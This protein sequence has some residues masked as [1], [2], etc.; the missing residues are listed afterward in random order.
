MTLNSRLSFLPITASLPPCWSV[1]ERYHTQDQPICI[2][3]PCHP[4]PGLGGQPTPA[5]RWQCM[6]RWGKAN[7]IIGSRGRPGSSDWN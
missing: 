3:S 6:C 5:T 4:S 7:A 1:I 2:P